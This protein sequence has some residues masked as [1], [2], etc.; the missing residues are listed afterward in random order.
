M[1][2]TNFQS[3]YEPGLS[4]KVTRASEQIQG[5]VA[6]IGSTAAEKVNQNRGNAATSMANAAETLHRRADQLQMSGEKVSH[7]AHTAADRL[8]ETAEY[9]RDNDLYSMVDDLE[10]LVKR[11]PGP[12]L[13]V[14]VG[15]GFLVGRAFEGTAR[16]YVRE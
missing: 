2:T 14:A 7:M 12:A 13:A 3:D 4:E 9:V 1:S 8:N 16:G 11:N 10:R 6:E 5:K 15:L